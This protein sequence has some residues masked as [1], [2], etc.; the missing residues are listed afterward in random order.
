LI[1]YPIAIRLRCLADPRDDALRAREFWLAI[2]AN[3]ARA[4]L[5][6]ERPANVTDIKR[7]KR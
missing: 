6:R 4:W 7:A 3:R 1:R 5:E 2:R